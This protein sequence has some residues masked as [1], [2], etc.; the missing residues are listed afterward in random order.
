MADPRL[1]PLPVYVATWKPEGDRDE[2]LRAMTHASD[3]AAIGAPVIDEFSTESLGTGLRVLVRLPV[4][5]DPNAI[6]GALSYAWRAGKPQTDLRIFTA[7]PDLGRLQRA[8]GD[9]DQLARVTA[10]VPLP[11]A[12]GAED[13]SS[14]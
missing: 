6:G 9:I 3:P 10:I 2:A 5:D 4:E 1:A 12:V 7:C 14:P 13:R 8:I 11:G